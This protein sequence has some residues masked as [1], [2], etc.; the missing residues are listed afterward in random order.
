MENFRP[1]KMLHGYAIGDAPK[2]D[3]NAKKRIIEKRINDLH[4]KGYG[5]IVT[6]VDMDRNYLQDEES[7]ILF[8]Y[9]INYAVKQHGMAIWLYDEKGYHKQ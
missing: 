4:T 1:L 6:N 9:A 8:D 7:W 5:G 3:L 2:D